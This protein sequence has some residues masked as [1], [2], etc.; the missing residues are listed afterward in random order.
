MAQSNPNLSSKD[1]IFFAS[2]VNVRTEEK[3]CLIRSK[4][5]LIQC[6]KQMLH[7]PGM[8]AIVFHTF[9]IQQ[10]IF[11]DIPSGHRRPIHPSW[12]RDLA[13]NQEVPSSK[14]HLVYWQEKS[15]LK[16]FVPHLY[17][18][19]P[20]N[21]EL[22]P[23]PIYVVREKTHTQSLRKCRAR[24]ISGV[25]YRRQPKPLS[26]WRSPLY[27]TYGTISVIGISIELFYIRSIK[28]HQSS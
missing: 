27:L 22:R 16:S 2:T 19:M 17:I 3:V 12:L 18:C 24:T 10:L 8:K 23:H 4:V 5:H 20:T 25:S 9:T 7:K 28:Y 21:K 11:R 14:Y 15:L 26:H 1:G 6:F 13:V